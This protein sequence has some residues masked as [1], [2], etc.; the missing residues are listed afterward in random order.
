MTEDVLIRMAEEK[1]ARELL[2]IYAPYVTDTAITF[3]YEVPEL[4]DFA[5]RIRQTLQRYP[6]LVIVQ[7]GRI[8]GYAYASAF[9]TRAAYDWAVE[10]SVYMRQDCRGAGLGSRLYLALEE[11]LRRQN[12]LNLNACIAYPRETGPYLDDSSVRFHERFDYEK[13]AHFTKCAHKFDQWYDMIWMEKMIGEH[14]EKP[15][16]IIPAGE[17]DLS[18]FQF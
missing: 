5:G 10:T 4:E 9:K 18:S 7:S 2:E 8:C 3:E 16:P 12:I 14:P 15:E 13:V 1:D 6:Y 17:L 11:M